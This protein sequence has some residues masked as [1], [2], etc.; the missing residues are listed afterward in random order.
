MSRVVLLWS[1]GMFSV[2]MS[3][4]RCLYCIHVYIYILYTEACSQRPSY[5]CNLSSI[6]GT[7][8]TPLT[9]VSNTFDLDS[10]TLDVAYKSTAC[11]EADFSQS[12]LDS[13]STYR[14]TAVEMWS[15]AFVVVDGCQWAFAYFMLDPCESLR[16]SFKICVQNNV[17]CGVYMVG[18]HSYNPDS[19]PCRCGAIVIPEGSC[20]LAQ[21]PSCNVGT[22]EPVVVNTTCLIGSGVTSTGDSGGSTQPSGTDGPS[23]STQPSGTNGPSSSTQPSGTNGLSSSTQPPGT[24]GLSSSTQPAGTNGLSSQ[25]PCRV[26]GMYFAL[27]SILSIMNSAPHS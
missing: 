26:H 21:Q 17:D 16:E 18:N 10:N 8:A 27:A 3:C 25:A 1:F 15:K 13:L 2:K 9:C 19:L 6:D 20:S 4:C 12:A 22:R 11:T 24:N 14:S 23:S 7:G 5:V